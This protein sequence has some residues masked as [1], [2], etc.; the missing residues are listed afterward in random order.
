VLADLID[1]VVGALGPSFKLTPPRQG[2]TFRF[3]TMHLAGRA[4]VGV[5]IHLDDEDSPDAYVWGPESLLDELQR[6]W[7]Q[8][9]RVHLQGTYQVKVLDDH[10]PD[11]CERRRTDPERVRS[12]GA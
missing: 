2:R 8:N 1:T 3:P 4:A 10:Q 7:D 5:R 12:V 9:G 6:W 11:A